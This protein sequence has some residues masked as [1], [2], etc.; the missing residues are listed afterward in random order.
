MAD[1]STLARPYAKAAFQLAREEGKLAQ[2][3]A[4]LAAI[5]EAVAHPQIATLLGNPALTRAQLVGLLSDVL[6]KQLDAQG[7]S[8]LKILAEN[9]RLKTAS[10]IRSQFEALKAEAE[11]RIE[12]EVTSA[13]AVDGSLKDQ[14]AAS[15]A[16]RLGRDVSVRWKTDESLVAGALIR[17][18]DLIIDGSVRG[19]LEKLHTLLAR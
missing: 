18:G 12:V 7:R 6:D 3:S 1:F 13:A 10:A 17:A 16:K 5:A 9:G 11:K 2:W 14:L 15:I 8:F 19:E 4:Q